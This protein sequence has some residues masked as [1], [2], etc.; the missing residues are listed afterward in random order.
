MTVTEIV[1]KYLKENGFTGLV[2][3]D[4]ECGCPIDGLRLCGESW[5]ECAPGY[6]HFYA[7]DCDDNS[8]CGQDVCASVKGDWCIRENDIRRRIAEEE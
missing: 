4:T 7:V 8:D 6:Q 5:A 1:K 3:A 2:H